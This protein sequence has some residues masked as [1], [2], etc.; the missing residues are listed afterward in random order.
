LPYTSS[1][2]KTIPHIRCDRHHD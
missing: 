2:L 1:P